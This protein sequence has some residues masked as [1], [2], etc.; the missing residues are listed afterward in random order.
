MKKLLERLNQ[1]T[2]CYRQEGENLQ[3][4]TIVTIH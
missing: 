2:W 1:G 4:I 3:I